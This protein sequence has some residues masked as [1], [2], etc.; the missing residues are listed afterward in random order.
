MYM[1]GGISFHQMG[2][3][4]GKKNSSLVPEVIILGIVNL[5]R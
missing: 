3:S 4:S 2:D 1:G 5:S